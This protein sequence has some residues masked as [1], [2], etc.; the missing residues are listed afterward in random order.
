MLSVCAPALSLVCLP[1]EK[2]SVSNLSAAS[3]GG[4]SS[5]MGILSQHY[6]FKSPQL[7]FSFLYKS[8]QI[9]GNV[10]CQLFVLARLVCTS[11]IG[12]W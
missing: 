5:Y 11:R 8:G 1:A 12:L 2:V 4:T 3:V 9:A 7:R 6:F 10:I